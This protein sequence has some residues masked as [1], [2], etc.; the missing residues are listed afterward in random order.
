M[1]NVLTDP[2]GPLRAFVRDGR[3]AAFPAKRVRRLALLDHVA[4]VFEPGRDY[5]EPV[6]DK[7]LKGMTDDHCALRRY[8]VDEQFLSRNNAG[9]YWRTGGAINA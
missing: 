1:D 3:I 7:I 4:Q 6:V 5:T 2:P 9:L 8:L